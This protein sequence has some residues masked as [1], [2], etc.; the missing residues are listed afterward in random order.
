MNRAPLIV[1]G[2]LGEYG[3]GAFA[4]LGALTA[5]RRYRLTGEREHVD[6]SMFEA[7]HLTMLTTPTLMAPFR[8]VASTRFDL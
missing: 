5:W 4:A 1:G 8:A 6:V 2:R 7:M 3:T